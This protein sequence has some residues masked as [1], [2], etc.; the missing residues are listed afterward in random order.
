MLRSPPLHEAGPRAGWTGAPGTR[1]GVDPP[2]ARWVP[3]PDAL[4]WSVLGR[5]PRPPG[6]PGG[7]MQGV[8]RPRGRLFW[9]YVVLFAGLVSAA[10][11]A[12]GLVELYFS[13]RENLAALVG[14]PAGA[15][16]RRRREDRGVPPRHR[17]PG[18]LGE[19]G[20]GRHPADGRAAALRVHPPPA[21]GARGHR[22][23]PARPA[24]PGAA[25]RLPPRHG[26]GRQPGRLLLR[27][28]VQGGAPGPALLRPRVLPEGV[29]ALPDPVG[30]RRR[31]HG[32]DRRRGQPQVHLGRRLPDPDRVHRARLRRGR[33]GPAGRPPGH[34]PRPPE[35][36]PLAARS[37][38]GRARGPADARRAGP[39]GHRRPGLRQ[40]ARS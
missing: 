12:S 30:R 13:Y 11:L 34:Q 38:P 6:P 29:R 25:P 4:E 23:E 36:R 31:R 15:G 3:R 1:P 16:G 14:P 21:P 20:P 18:G 17:A 19:P 8:V 40:G 5:L 27:S 32:R 7:C 9:K 2:S 35:D 33:P 39:E 22:G 28:A 37:G 24:G 10:L 26:R